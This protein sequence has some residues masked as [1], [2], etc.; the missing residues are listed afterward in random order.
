MSKLSE[1]LPAGSGAKSAEFVASGT[2]ASGQ[3]V[4]L[5]TDGTVT[6][7]S[8]TG[9][10]PVIN[11][12]AVFDTRDI[13]RM[14]ACYDTASSK[15]VVAYTELNVGNYGVAVVGYVSGNTI[16]FG[17][18]VTFVSAF[19][20]NKAIVE[21]NG[22]SGVVIAFQ[23][24]GNSAYGTAIV[25]AV[26]GMSISFGTA[27]VFSSANTSGF[28][29]A[30]QSNNGK[31]VI[32]YSVL[33]GNGKVIV[34]TVSGGTS[35]SFGSP[36]TLPVE[37]SYSAATFDA[38]AD[39]I[40]V[41]YRDGTT[42]GRPGKVAVGTVSGTTISFITPVTFE[43]GNTS[44]VYAC[45]AKNINKHIVV[46]TDADNSDSTTVLVASLSGSSL[47]FGTPVV[48]AGNSSKSYGIA[49]DATSQKVL[50]T[51][52]F[53]NNAVAGY[54]KVGTISGASI[55]FS[56]QQTLT[57]TAYA[58]HSASPVAN[59]GTGAGISFAVAYGAE[60]AGNNP[61]T[62]VVINPSSSN[63]P[64]F[65]GI[66]DQVIANTATGA[67]I[68]QGGVNSKVTSLTIGSDYYVQSNGTLSTTVT[69]A[70]AGRALSTTSILLEG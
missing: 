9:G 3:A 57:S 44:F 21:D 2:L 63:S 27:V 56:A 8:A 55:S 36:A 65:V 49:Y 11:T 35:I 20:D 42:S 1:L 62:G 46:F 47:S 52:Y 13:N 15:V 67:V 30:Y 43:A 5:K 53:I 22:A 70:P 29:A 12:P 37:I 34:G 16:S 66:T 25:G 23:N 51:Y 48:I 19:A 26:S 24:R 10:D 59:H 39:K 38:T 54:F 58:Y 69:A 68:V 14:W 40:L 7:I 41:W 61:G 17:T 32:S 6:A 31:T 45:Y 18:P 50:I 64:S 60:V 28:G 4:A 33:S